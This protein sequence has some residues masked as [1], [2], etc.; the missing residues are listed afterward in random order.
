[1][2]IKYLPIWPNRR[3]LRAGVSNVALYVLNATT[4]LHYRFKLYMLDAGFKES[5]YKVIQKE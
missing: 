1:M 5:K 2:W 4:E 3:G